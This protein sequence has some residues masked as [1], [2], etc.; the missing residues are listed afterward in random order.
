MYKFIKEC[1]EGYLI[2]EEDIK[3]FEKCWNVKIPEILRK[4]YINYNGGKINLCKFS[5]D[6]FVYEISEIIPLKYGECCLEE[7]I[8]N[9]RQDEIIPKDKVP[10]ANDRGGNYYYWDSL[11][12]EIFLYYC[13]DI[14]NPIYICKSIEDLF[15][16]MNQSCYRL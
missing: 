5:V 3:E 12:G 2:S 6:D 9:D 4:F 14:E 16:V 13:D 15:E 7:V 10:I 8:R 1:R 11:T